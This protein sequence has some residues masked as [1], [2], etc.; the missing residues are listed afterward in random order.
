LVAA[1]TTRFWRGSIP[2]ISVS[3]CATRRFSASPDT[4]P[5]LGAIE[6]ISSMKMIDGA[7]CAASSKT[8]RSRFSLSP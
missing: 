8:S 5:R 6:S 4:W 2:S 1:I 3:S 7:D